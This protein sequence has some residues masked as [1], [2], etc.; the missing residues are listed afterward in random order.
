M[1]IGGYKKSGFDAGKHVV[2]TKCANIPSTVYYKL[3]IRCWWVFG[4]NL[5]WIKRQFGLNDN[6]LWRR[7]TI[8]GISGRH[9]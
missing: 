1:C 2:E 9:V 3:I 8:S 7:S 6:P 4:Y 5:F